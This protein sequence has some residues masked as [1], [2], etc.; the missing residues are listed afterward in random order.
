MGSVG[1]RARVALAMFSV[2]ILAFIFMDVTTHGQEIVDS[3]LGDFK[4][5]RTSFA[6]VMGLFAL[7]A[8][9]FTIGTAGIAAVER[10]LRRHRITSPPIAG[11]EAGSRIQPQRPMRALNSTPAV[12][13]SAPE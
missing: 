11:G 8:A 5:H 1:D 12:R 10:V 4:D 13:R 9:G 7:L 3:T 2:G 6:H